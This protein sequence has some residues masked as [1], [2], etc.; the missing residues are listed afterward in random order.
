[1]GV[2]YFYFKKKKKKK[3]VFLLVSIGLLIVF[4]HLHSLAS[5]V[6]K[7]KKMASRFVMETAAN[8]SLFAKRYWRCE[9]IH[10][11]RLEKKKKK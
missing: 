8:V 11:H 1:M 6:T 4:L 5:T 2:S 7:T 9:S 3:K 10:F